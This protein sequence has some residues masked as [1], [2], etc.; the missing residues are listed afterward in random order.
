[1]DIDSP[2]EKRP[3]K[4]IGLSNTFKNT[5]MGPTL[6]NTALLSGRIERQPVKTINLHLRLLLQLKAV[7]GVYFVSTVSSY[8]PQ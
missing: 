5:E 6:L 7:Y 3:E 2:Q 8:T 1:M 4:T